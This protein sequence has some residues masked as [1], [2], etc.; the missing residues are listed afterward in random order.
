MSKAFTREDLPEAAP[1]V[2]KRAQLPDGVPNYMT[3]RGLELLHQERVRL[4]EARRSA[5][6]AKDHGALPNLDANLEALD[7]RIASAELVEPPSPPPEE[8]RFGARVRVVDESD[9]EHELE[10]VGVDEADLDSRKIAFIA[11]LARAL[12]GKREGDIALVKTPRREDHAS[13]EEEY[14]I[15]SVRYGE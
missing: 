15:L 4:L 8:I 12:L 3:P 13:G 10:I 11:P 6:A 2:I 14:E 7:A 5:L 1:I 9:Q